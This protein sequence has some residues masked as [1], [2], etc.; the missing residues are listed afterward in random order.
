MFEHRNCMVDITQTKSDYKSQ[1]GCKKADEFIGRF[2]MVD[3]VNIYPFGNPEQGQLV[4]RLKVGKTLTGYDIVEPIE[5]CPFCGN[6]FDGLI[7]K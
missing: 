4:F 6:R 5:Y 2:D 1:C 7:T 3:V